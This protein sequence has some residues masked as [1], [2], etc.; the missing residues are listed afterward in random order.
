MD[1]LELSFLRSGTQALRYEGVCLAILVFNF[2]H[3]FCPSLTD[4]IE[5]HL[6]YG[7][8]EEHFHEEMFILIIRLFIGA[9]NML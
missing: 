6:F 1:L 4:W 2:Q 3:T 7:N 5:I 9:I 8:S